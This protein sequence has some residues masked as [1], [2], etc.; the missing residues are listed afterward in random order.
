MVSG[1]EFDARLRPGNEVVRQRKSN[2]EHRFQRRNCDIPD[3]RLY[4]LTLSASCM[5]MPWFSPLY[6]PYAVSL[7]HLTFGEIELHGA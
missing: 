1:H 6:V 3:Q 2:E 7:P 4:A 5:V